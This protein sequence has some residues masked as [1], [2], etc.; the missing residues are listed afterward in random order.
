MRYFI[1]AAQAILEEEGIKGLTIRK[2]ADKAGYNSATL[3]SYFENLEHLTFYAS[4]KYLRSYLLALRDAELPSDALQRFLMI[5]RLFS[6]ES[7]RNP[8]Y[9]YNIFFMSQHFKFNDSIRRYFEIYPEELDGLSEDL[10]PMLLETNIYQRDFESLKRCVKDGYILD[11]DVAEINDIIVLLFESYLQRVRR[12]SPVVDNI[13][14]VDTMM[15]YL[16]SLLKGYVC[17]AKNSR[18]SEHI[19]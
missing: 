3:Y 12:E 13:T 4:L 8:D 7:F 5:W 9:Y 11:K 19:K 18:T 17:R 15:R 10:L 2:V 16:E 14:H 6:I 1:D